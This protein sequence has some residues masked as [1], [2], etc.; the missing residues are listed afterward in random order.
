MNTVIGKAK[1][2]HDKHWSARFIFRKIDRVYNEELNWGW[3]RFGVKPI[4]CDLSHTHLLWP[5]LPCQSFQ[6]YGAIVQACDSPKG[7]KHERQYLCYFRFSAVIVV[8]HYSN[9][10]A[11]VL[12]VEVFSWTFSFT[13]ASAQCWRPYINLCNYG[14][15]SFIYACVFN[16]CYI[17]I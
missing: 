16:Y 9:N 3:V 14:G 2:D 17:D 7:K 5:T 8:S 11:T 13:S 15:K 10:S 6:E 12:L 4:Q 1:W